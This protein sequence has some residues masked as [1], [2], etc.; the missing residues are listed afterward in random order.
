MHLLLLQASKVQTVAFV[1]V[2]ILFPCDYFL[3]RD[4]PVASKSGARPSKGTL[5]FL[6]LAAFQNVLSCVTTLVGELRIS[7]LLLDSVDD[8]RRSIIFGVLQG[9][10]DQICR[11]VW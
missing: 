3:R 4:S 5:F 1:V 11:A 7:T 9:W 10:L 8:C 2:F 6:K